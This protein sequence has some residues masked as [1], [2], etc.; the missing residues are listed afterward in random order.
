MSLFGLSNMLPLP[1]SPS[2]GSGGDPN[3][4]VREYSL[5]RGSLLSEHWCLCYP[6]LTPR[7]RLKMSYASAGCA[8]EVGRR[9]GHCRALSQ[10]VEKD[11]DGDAMECPPS[12]VIHHITT[13][14][15]TGEGLFRLGTIV[16]I[17]VF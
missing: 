14:L 6:V 13:S 8:A 10:G 4:K 17:F 3:A 12:F 5:G 15:E 16:S 1:L 7:C 2:T 11:K 9:R